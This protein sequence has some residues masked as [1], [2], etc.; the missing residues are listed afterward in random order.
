DGLRG[1]EFLGG[2]RGQWTKGKSADRFAPWGPWLVT[3]DEIAA[4]QA[5]G[6]WLD[7]NNHRF[8][9]SSTAEMVVGVAGLISYVSQFMRLLP[10]DVILTGT[11]A[12]VGLGHKPPVFLKEG[13]VVRAGIAGLGEQSHRAVAWQPAQA[14]ARH[15]QLA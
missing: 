7:V 3:I 1:G 5:L 13:D 8:Q 10:A 12:G 4:P 14:G 11:P 6:M 2:G 9:K 15:P